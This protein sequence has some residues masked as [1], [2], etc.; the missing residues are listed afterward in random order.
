M[1]HLVLI[2]S[3]VRTRTWEVSARGTHVTTTSPSPNKTTAHFSVFIK[4]P[5]DKVPNWL[6]YESK[7][8]SVDFLQAKKFQTVLVQGHSFLSV[9]L[10][11]LSTRIFIHHLKWIYVPLFT[12]KF[13]AKRLRAN[14]EE[15]PAF[16]RSKSFFWINWEEADILIHAMFGINHFNFA[17]NYISVLV[18]TIWRRCKS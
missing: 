4:F 9:I 2:N 6:V 17:Q 8:S 5:K 3:R 15:T 1:P 7:K 13:S 11:K 12:T 10:K 16:I 14:Y 18:M